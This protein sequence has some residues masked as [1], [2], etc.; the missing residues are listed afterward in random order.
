M[1][2]PKVP[3]VPPVTIAFFCHLVDRL[4]CQ[5][6]EAFLDS[7]GEFENVGK[8]PHADYTGILTLAN[9]KVILRKTEKSAG[10]RRNFEVRIRVGQA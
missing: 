8:R 9:F 4:A 10:V 5:M 2:Y 6:A 1:Q 7:F 3:Y